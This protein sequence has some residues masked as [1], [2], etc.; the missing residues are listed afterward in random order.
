[1]PK[2]T[3][4]GKYRFRLNAW[5]EKNPNEDYTNGAPIEMNVVAASPAPQKPFPWWIIAVIGAVAVAGALVVVLSSKHGKKPEVKTIVPD[6]KNMN[7]HD[8]KTAIQNTTLVFS[9]MKNGPSGDTMTWLSTQQ[10]PSAGDSAKKGDTV[11][12]DFTAIDATVSVPNVK[13]NGFAGARALI[14]DARLVF[15]IGKADYSKDQASWIAEDQSPAAGAKVKAGATVTV[16]F[17]SK[18]PPVSEGQGD[19]TYDF[20]GDGKAEIL[21]KNGWGVGILKVSGTGFNAIVAAKNGTRVDGGWLLN[22]ADNKFKL[23]ADF[24]H[25]GMA[26]IQVSSPWGIGIW[27]L[28]GSTLASPVMAA[29]GTR[30]S[31]G[32]WLLNTTDN[33]F[34]SAA[35]FDGDTRKEIMVSSPWGIGIWKVSGS[36][37]TAPV[38]A[39]N[40]T[41]FEGGWLLNTADNKFNFSGDFDGDK[42]SEFFVSSPWG[43][44]ILKVSGTTIT[45]R[46][47]AANGTRFE[48]GWLLNTGDNKF[49]FAGDFDGDKKDEIM[50]SSPWGIGILKVSGT[51]I[52]SR[53]M[54][55]NGTRFEGGWLLGT[56]DNKFNF[57]G[58]FD[59]DKLSEILVSSPWGIGILK[60][61]GTTITSRVMAANGTRFEG[62]WL[63]NTGDNIFNF[64]GDFDGDKKD[65]IMISS[66]WGIGI[67][68]VSG[69][70]ITSPV[71]AANG[72]RFG[73]WL[74]NTR[75][76]DFGIGIF[77]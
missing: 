9:M 16:S 44:G 8:A 72:T 21:M 2:G 20:N 11:R 65:D 37:F 10:S 25:T 50:I 51:T 42:I 77:P 4:E 47:M 18:T 75:E 48:G 12:V 52:T 66:P 68:K 70:T 43:I 58:D 49:N 29:N 13:N 14:Q 3:K 59:G 40:G 17:S 56:G 33:N 54:A 71:M 39:A 76:K 73:D 27:K 28:A 67:L 55:A 22:T 1:V 61:S 53:V 31:G 60:V 24:D 34:N 23:S 5:E 69:T 63:L 32:G 6:V 38:M 15:A 74:L 64:P 30:F 7:Y 36:T 57:S 19:N 62:G 35:D 26:K 41:R 45:S 46:V